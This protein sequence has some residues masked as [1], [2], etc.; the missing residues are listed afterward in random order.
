MRKIKAFSILELLIV[1]III[2]ILSAITIPSY[3]KHI[4]K[5]K[6]FDVMSFANN[7]KLVVTDFYLN[8]GTWPTNKDLSFDKITSK[9][10]KSIKLHPENDKTNSFE[11]IT[12]ILKGDLKIENKQIDLI[13]SNDDFNITWSCQ[14][15]DINAIDKTL[16]PSSC[17]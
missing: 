4:L 15:S 5:A 14:P 12:I 1:F 11:K 9:Y 10:I 13:S 3:Q 8:Y 6:I 7:I 2:G 16:L 17:L